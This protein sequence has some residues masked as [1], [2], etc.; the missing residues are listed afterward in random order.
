MAASAKKPKGSGRAKQPSAV[1]KARGNK[2]LTKDEEAE[3]AS[4][5]TYAAAGD[6][7]PPPNLPEEVHDMFVREA[8]YM[9][10]LNGMVGKSVYGSE[11]IEM[12]AVMCLSYSRFLEYNRREPRARS[13]ENR[14]KYNTMKHKELAAYERVMKMLMLDPKSRVQI[15]GPSEQKDDE[16][17]VIG[18]I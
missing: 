13:L 9:S 1:V 17:D 7:V 16:E 4:M 2:H 11:D 12:L 5:E 14:Q 8:A 15:P 10:R 18:L 6:I 3:A